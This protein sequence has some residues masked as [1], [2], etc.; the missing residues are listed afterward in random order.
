MKREYSMKM[1][2]LQIELV[3]TSGDPLESILQKLLES[4]ILD[5]LPNHGILKTIVSFILSR[6]QGEVRLFDRRRLCTAPC[7]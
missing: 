3:M 6:F 4:D 1:P 7:E 5:F 2:Y